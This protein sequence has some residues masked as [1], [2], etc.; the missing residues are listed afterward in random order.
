MP[1]VNN[2]AEPIEVAFDLSPHVR[3][4]CRRVLEKVLIDVQLGLDLLRKLAD[5]CQLI[6]NLLAGLTDEGNQFAVVED[7]SPLG[8]CAGGGA[9]FGLRHGS[10]SDCEGA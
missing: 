1:L 7:L 6:L 5:L 4:Q 8:C 9:S 10:N 3:R 2:A